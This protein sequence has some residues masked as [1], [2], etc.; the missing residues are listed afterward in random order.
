MCESLPRYIL[1]GIAVMALAPRVPAQSDKWK[2]DAGHS[3]ATFLLMSSHAPAKPRVAGIAR[4]SGLASL[5]SEDPSKIA[6]R[7]SIY[8][9]GEGED[10]LTADDTLRPDGL[11]SLAFYSVL[12]FQSE[13]SITKQKDQVQLSG[14][15]TMTHVTR[16][17]TAAWSNS[18]T[19]SRYVDPDKKTFSRDATLTLLTSREAIA[20]DEKAGLLRLDFF[21]D[22]NREDF[23]ELWTS[24]PDSIWP[25][26]V[27]DRNCA[28]P[29]IQVD[30]RAYQGANCTGTVVGPAFVRAE[31]AS[32]PEGKPEAASHAQLLGDKIRI[33][34][35]LRL[36]S[37]E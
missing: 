12:S 6:L 31:F 3:H 21:A 32:S 16:A 7:M 36:K 10:L 34:F 17:G 15:L 20:A 25:A 28:M 14:E 5:N 24:L 1:A 22:I 37:S 13:R 11:A 19:G 26:V 4:V 29:P 27:D 9:E 18:Y 30:M 23:P 2:I 33:V 8:P 35:Q